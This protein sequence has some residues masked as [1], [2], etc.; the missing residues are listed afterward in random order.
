MNM[1]KIHAAALET[2]LPVV[3]EFKLR[4]AKH[5]KTVY[6]F[7]EGKDD[8]SFYRGFIE[9][10]L[11]A[12]WKVELWPAGSKT[13]VYR[14]LD[15]F[16]WRRFPKQRICF[17]V[18]RDLSDL[19]GT[20]TKQPP[21]LYV[22]PEYSIENVVAKKHVCERVLTELLGF[23]ATQ[24]EEMDAVGRQFEVQLEVFLKSMSETMAWILYWRKQE[25]PAS[26]S[27]IEMK[28]MF[29]VTNG[30][31]AS[32]PRP[33]NK[34]SAKQY[35]HEQCGLTLL[36]DDDIAEER[37]V[38]AKPGNYRS[39]TRGKYVFWF[40]IEFCKSVHRGAATVFTG[41]PKPLKVRI[42]LSA[43]NAF[44]L[45]APRCRIPPCLRSF[46]QSTYGAYVD[47]INSKTANA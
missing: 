37:T 36:P 21:N 25:R 9:Q 43:A 33:K 38:F 42:E 45:V 23:S 34:P 3:H 47:R 28:H 14:I 40:L 30:V 46:L 5:A 22:T 32:T 15:G 4:Y 41:V 12:D 44:A 27:N 1:L 24:H 29:S 19:L 13:T 11:P 20:F 31:V 39:F 2:E 6:G 16:D 26:L 8:P 18:D 7:V 17:F 35:I 10:I